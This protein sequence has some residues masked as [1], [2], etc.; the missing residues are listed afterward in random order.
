MSTL[1]WSKYC[2]LSTCEFSVLLL[3]ALNFYDIPGLKVMRLMS[4]FTAD[5]YFENNSHSLKFHHPMDKFMVDRNNMTTTV[6][7]TEEERTKTVVLVYT[8]FFG[9]VKWIGD[10]DNCGFENKFLFASNKC[11][12][13]DFELIYDKQRFEESDL[14][15][16]H[17]RNMP[18][19]DHLRTLLKSRPTSQR[20]VYALWES[21]NL[22]PNPAPLNGLFNSTW[23]YR[24]DSDFWS[25]YGS[26]EELTEEEKIDKMKNIPDY[27]Q[28]KT[29]LVAWMVSNCRA[30]PRMAFVQNLKKYIKV[31]VFGR[32]SGKFGQHRGCRNLAACLKTFK[33]YLAFENALCEDYITEKYWGRLGKSLSFHCFDS[34][35][36][37]LPVR[38]VLQVNIK[39]FKCQTCHVLNLIHS[40]H[41]TVFIV[42]NL[43]NL[44]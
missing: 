13:G 38:A 9:T 20:W 39:K 42:L 3:A 29:K 12:S 33:F 6:Q 19:V 28:G 17:A 43:L 8:V 7:P 5:I 14:V 2:F 44:L 41:T 35:F 21:P 11:L 4:N 1:N 40:P 34:C 24:S 30:Q 31:D 10:R 16:F 25:P 22:T 32:C 26:Y 15:V 23:T 18:S 36:E 27:S 37:N